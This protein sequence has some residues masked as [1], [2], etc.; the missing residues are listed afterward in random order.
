M[1]FSKTTVP[2]ITQMELFN[3]GLESIKLNFK[4][5]H[6][7][8][9]YQIWTSL[10]HYGQW[11][12]NRFPPPISLMQL[13]VVL[14][15]EWYKIPLEIVRNFYESIPRRTAA[16]LKAKMVQHHTNINKEMFTL[17]VV[18]PLLSSTALCVYQSYYSHCL[19]L[20]TP[21]FN[22]ILSFKSLVWMVLSTLSISSGISTPSYPSYWFPF[23]QSHMPCIIQ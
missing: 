7:Q 21:I 14:Q 9:N 22:M 6:D 3:Y 8:H 17:S 19:R 10:N 16:L 2:Q 1:Q 23:Q 13:E 20:P 5:F 11:V 18:F 12:R 4:I 15:E